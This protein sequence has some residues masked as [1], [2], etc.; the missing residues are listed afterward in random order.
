MIDWY[1]EQEPLL[2]DIRGLI[3]KYIN[4][5]EASKDKFTVAAYLE[6]YHYNFKFQERHTEIL[7]LND[8]NFNHKY[9]TD[10]FLKQ[11]SEA[12]EK[13][14][15]FFIDLLISFE[16]EDV[17]DYSIEPTRSGTYCIH[18]HVEVFTKL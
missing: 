3:D 10:N 7:G 12:H 13:T 15:C 17:L 1:K 5:A 11:V 9:F 6:R 2:D 4:D 14:K 18:S 8:V 16:G